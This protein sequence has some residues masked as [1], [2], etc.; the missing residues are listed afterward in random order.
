MP[1]TRRKLI[2]SGL[3]VGGGLVVYSA[4]RMLDTGGDGDARV[5]FAAST[6]DHIGLNAWIKIAPDGHICFAVHRAEMGQGVTTALPMLLA[7]E[8]D[9]DWTKISYEFSPVDKDYYNFGVM[10]RGLPFGEIEGRPLAAFGTKLMRRMFHARGDSLTLSS[11]SII[12]AYDTLRPAA[13]AARA[14]LVQAAAERWGVATDT[15]VTQDS[16]VLDTA[17]DRKLSYG[18]LADAAALLEPPAEPMLKDPADYKIIGTS[19]ARLD[20]PAKVTGSAE[21]A[22]D[23]KLPNTLC[24]VVVHSPIAGGNIAKFDASAAEAVAGVESVIRLSDKAL[25]VIA[26]DTWTAFKAAKL[27]ELESTVESEPVESSELLANYYDALDAPEP[28]LFVEE[29]DA[30]A[31]LEDSA[32]SLTALYDWPFLAHACM[33]PMN[34]TAL[35]EDG[36]LNVWAPTQAINLAQNMAAEAAGLELNQVTMHRVLLGGGFGRRAEMDFIEHAATAAVSVPGRAVKMIYT[37]EQDMENDMY[38]PAGVARLQA[39]LTEDGRIDAFNCDL[40]TQSVVANFATRT[41]TPQPANA[42]R[43][44]TVAKSLYDFLYDVPNRRVAFNPQFPHVPVGYWRST[45]T[46]YGAFCA[47]VFVDELA[48]KAGVDPIEFRLQNLAPDD[49]KRAVLEL[50]AEKSAWNQSLQAGRGRGVALFVKALT[51]IAQVAEVTVADDGSYSVDRI[52]GVID[53]GQVIHPDT[54]VAMMEGG[55]LFGVSAALYGEIS[56][57]DGKPQQNNFHTYREL[58]IAKQPQV[59]VHIL[60]QG[61]RPQGV[62]ETAVPGAAPAI[63]NAIYAATGKRLRSLPLGDRIEA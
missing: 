2:F 43:D 54:V 8:L 58:P 49:P 11:T 24:G 21:Y 63:A 31:V 5:K 9:A 35:F 17:N 1:I 57:V 44:K 23:V 36:R 34:C 18:D 40:V 47:E 42:R 10:G 41:P 25:G 55:I 27:L 48:A 52:V 6:P 60:A 28:S 7:E 16:Q 59:E 38:R 61:G 12:D 53:P 51:V 62:G 30:Q 32:N 37:R 14:V 20:I 33:E 46:S 15:L 19:P 56:F 4:S 29:G 3:A 22:M 50:V 13:A 45:A 26:R 39:H